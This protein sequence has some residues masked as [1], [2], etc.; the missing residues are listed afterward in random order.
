MSKFKGFGDSESST[1]VPDSLFSQLLAEIEDVDELKVALFALWRIEHIDGTV[2][3]LHDADFDAMGLGLSVGEIRSGLEK[4]VRRG[5][6]LVSRHGEDAAYFLNSPRGRAAAEGFAGGKVQAP[7]SAAPLERPNVFRLYEENIGPLTPLIADTLKNAEE[8]YSEEWVADAIG[9]AVTHNKRSWKYCEAILKRWK[10]EGRAEK[11]NR[12]DDPAAR[13][14]DIED[15]V[16]KYL[17]G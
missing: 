16:R 13:R 6:L 7:G 11:Q 15:K 1:Q 10:E 4:A 2:R 14:R 17:G 5:V 8:V 12:R 3:A 9:L